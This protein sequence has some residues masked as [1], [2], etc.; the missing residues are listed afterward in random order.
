MACSFPSH[1]LSETLE[2]L[3]ALVKD[4]EL[5]TPQIMKHIKGPDF[6]TGGILLSSKTEI[7]KAYEEG[8]GALKMRGEWETEQ[9]PVGRLRS[10]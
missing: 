9:L 5:S 10:L 1:N 4:R 3:K 2:A 8:Q 6:P 7:R